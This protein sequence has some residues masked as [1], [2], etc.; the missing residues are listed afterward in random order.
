MNSFIDPIPG[1]TTIA[2]LDIAGYCFKGIYS[3]K[4]YIFKK[5]YQILLSK[6]EVY[7]I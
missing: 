5:N 2:S 1:E 3:S 6:V 7:D 4:N